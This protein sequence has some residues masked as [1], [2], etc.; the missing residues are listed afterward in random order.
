MTICHRI[1]AWK[2]PRTSTEIEEW[3]R[4]ERS[5]NAQ[6]LSDDE[7]PLPSFFRLHELWKR[8]AKPSVSDRKATRERQRQQAVDESNR[9]EQE[10]MER[11]GQTYYY[12]KHVADMTDATLLTPVFAILGILGIGL[13]G[14]AWT[15]YELYRVLDRIG[16]KM[17]RPSYYNAEARRRAAVLKHQRSESHRIRHRTSY[18]LPPTKEEILEAWQKAH[19]RGAI[20]EKLHLGELLATLEA[21]VDNGLQR[22]LSGEIVGRNPGIKGWLGTHCLEL[23]PHYSTLMRYKAAADKQQTVCGYG[24]PFPAE[25]LMAEPVSE[26]DTTITV[27]TEMRGMRHGPDSDTRKGRHAVIAITV[28]IVF[29]GKTL[30]LLGVRDEKSREEII[31][32]AGYIDGCRRRARQIWKE[33]QAANA[34]HSLQAFDDFLYARL[35]LVRERR[36]HLSR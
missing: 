36:P 34:L 20:K 4:L 22:N 18:L 2:R 31:R 35:G 33:A 17:R 29:E 32:H 28:G 3:Q 25:A 16:N 15:G 19:R 7:G 6:L 27:G 9:R 21:S 12:G 26:T 5:L 30:H 13:L 11:C 10:K 8:D 14:A 23:L 1:H 24:D